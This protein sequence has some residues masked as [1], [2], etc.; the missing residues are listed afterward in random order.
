[1]KTTF[2]VSLQIALALL[3]CGLFV[4]PPVLAA[5]DPVCVQCHGGLEG[6]LSAPVAQ[7][8]NSIH[9]ANGISCEDCHGGDPTDFQMAMSPQRG[10]IGVP[11]YT[12]VPDFCGRCHVGVKEDYLASAHG[13][14]L[15]RGGAQCVICHGSHAIEEAHIDLINEQ[16]CSRCH[17]YER[18]AAVKKEISD[19]EE[20][21]SKLETAVASLHRV[22]I[23]TERLENELFAS[24]NAFRQLFHTVN[25]EKIRNQIAEFDAELSDT[26]STIDDY[27]K[28]LGQRKLI[29]GVVVLLLLL[30]GCVAWLIRRSYHQEE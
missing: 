9:A 14:A 10:F 24:R 3:I 2:S 26:R 16:S 23:D 19:T 17:D 18:A 7:W 12:E 27:Q 1:M 28:T 22:G 30:G 20:T 21:L 29:G 25:I 13:Q 8:K 4:T 15:E 11:G 5:D 6:H